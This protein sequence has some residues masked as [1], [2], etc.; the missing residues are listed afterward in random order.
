MS[1]GKPGESQAVIQ[2]VKEQIGRLIEQ[3]TAAEKMAALV[4][5]TTDDSRKYKER[6]SRIKKLTRQLAE[7]G[8]EQGAHHE[9]EEA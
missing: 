3:Q 6:H 9:Q 7:L 4:G 1:D 5:M 2:R 8:S